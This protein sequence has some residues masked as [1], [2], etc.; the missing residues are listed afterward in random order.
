[1]ESFIDGVNFKG[2]LQGPISVC[3]AMKDVQRG[4]S[5]GSCPQCLPQLKAQS[6]PAPGRLH[7]CSQLQSTACGR[8]SKSKPEGGELFLGNL[9]FPGFPTLTVDPPSQPSI[10]PQT[11]LADR[12]LLY[13][14]CAHPPLCSIP[15]P[16]IGR[17][18]TGGPL[19]GMSRSFLV[20]PPEDQASNAWPPLCSLPIISVNN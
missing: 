20:K 11:R 8:Q 7:L 18:W 4:L 16:G 15:S 12:P 17:D 1:M 2:P 3:L 5:E 9:T 6:S 13:C 10:V 14:A 19:G